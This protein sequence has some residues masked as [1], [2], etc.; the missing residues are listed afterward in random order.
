MGTVIFI[1]IL[2]A[3]CVSAWKIGYDGLDGVVCTPPARAVYTILNITG[4]IVTT[5]LSGYSSYLAFSNRHDFFGWMIAVGT[6]ILGFGAATSI[7]MASEAQE[8]K[9]KEATKK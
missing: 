3:V 7:F 6:F 4:A 1:V 2:L 5:F 8:A 9:R